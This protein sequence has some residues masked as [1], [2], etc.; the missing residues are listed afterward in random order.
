MRLSVV[1]AVA[2][3]MIV[4]LSAAEEAPAS[5]TKQT[6]IPAQGLGVA[7]QSLARDRN[8]QIVYVSEEV[9]ALRTQGAIGE[10]TPEDAL[11]QLLKGTGLTFRYL[12]EKTVTILPAVAASSP[13]P[14]PVSSSGSPGLQSQTDANLRD[15]DGNAGRLRLAQ[16]NQIVPAESSTPE[17]A[18]DQSGQ[19]KQGT[20]AEV[21]VTGSRLPQA[22]GGGAQEVQTYTR[23]QIDQSGQGT[24]SDFLNTLPAVSV[25]VTESPARGF[26]TGTTIQLHGL[27]VGSTLVLVDG[28]RLEANGFQSTGSVTGFFDLNSLPLSV[29]DRIEV[30]SEGSSAIYGSDAL[31]GVVNIILKKDY[32]GFEATAR[33]GGASGGADDDNDSLAWGKHWDRGSVS[34]VGN[35]QNRSELL[36]SERALTASSN[37]TSYGAPNLNGYNCSPGNIYFPAGYSFNGGPAV[38]Y[39][40]VP[41]GYTGTPTISEFAATAGQSN[42]CGTYATQSIIPATRRYGLLASANFELT[43]SVELFTENLFSYSHQN[44]NYGNQVFYGEP[45]YQYY[46]VP[47]S[48][49]YNPFGQTVGVSEAIPSLPNAGYV[50]D[51]TFFRPS[52]GA[53][54]AFLSDWHWE[55]TGWSSED[56]EKFSFN[57]IFYNFAGVQA[58]FNSTNPATALNPFIDGPPGSAQL[59]RSLG[60][61]LQENDSGQTQGVNGYIHGPIVQLPSGPVAVV[62][63]AEYDHDSVY[64]N[65]GNSPFAAPPLSST[66]SRNTYATF[67]EV[68]IPLIGS[69]SSP[70]VGDTLAITAAGRYD[71][72]SDIGSKTT[73]QVKLEWRPLDSLLVRASYGQAFQAPSLYAVH[74]GTL[75]TVEPLTDPLRNNELETVPVT[76]GGNS[77]LKP[78]TGD[79]ETEGFVYVSR[80]IP[81]LQV[82]LTHWRIDENNTIQSIA[83]QVIV[84]NANLFPGQVIRGAGPTGPITAVDAYFSNFGQINVQGL[85]YQLQD[86]IVTDAGQFVPSLAVTETYRYTAQ[87]VPGAALSNGLSRANLD[88]NWAP[89]WKGNAS[90]GWELGPYSLTETSRYVGRYQDYDAARVIGNFW[91]FDANFRYAIG[92]AWLPEGDWLRGAYVELGGVNLL[93]RLPQFSNY[94]GIGYD[95]AQADIRGRYLYVQAGLKW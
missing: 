64:T 77:K 22:A 95:P 45:G 27:P 19:K 28:H 21:V 80:A 83:P 26:G 84:D 46:S 71:H 89:R 82:S 78:Q 55:V 57:P 29:V 59:L 68:R 86:K 7:L 52:I 41:R 10:F 25:A 69:R 54:G 74:F 3:L 37:Y 63:G 70:S 11:R 67:S 49:P 90:V 6:N 75:T 20:L 8:L 76:N 39:A 16:A 79:S 43:P 62:A 92:K 5:V 65:Y 32:D 14:L 51:T 40:A 58:A 4:G 72:Y 91:I 1:F 73:P 33:H 81:G 56:K 12:D 61:D 23:Q 13:A 38:P 17:K 87:I 2:C 42:Q 60:F 35:F 36:G 9:G 30:V 47:A 50:T 18:S 53:R 44:Y 34:I 48:N 85:D 15:D 88:G 94:M 31:A 93:D 24:V 66:Y